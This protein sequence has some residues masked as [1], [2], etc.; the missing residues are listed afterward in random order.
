MCVRRDVRCIRKNKVVALT[1]TSGL[2]GGAW[3]LDGATRM[4]IASFR[5]ERTP[6]FILCI[7]TGCVFVGLTHMH[8]K[9]RARPSAYCA[10]VTK[11]SPGGFG[12]VG[13]FRGIGRK[14]CCAVW[15]ACTSGEHA[16]LRTAKTQIE[17]RRDHGRPRRPESWPLRVTQ[18][19]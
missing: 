12:R 4:G 10:A 15:V 18:S 5:T 19:R 7:A 2:T 6:L 14:N 1:R 17:L 9:D 16:R 11:R 3:E 13:R 8:R